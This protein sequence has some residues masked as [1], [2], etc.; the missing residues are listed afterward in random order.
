MYS[1]SKNTLSNESTM[2]KIAEKATANSNGFVNTTGLP[3]IYFCMQVSNNDVNVA[4]ATKIRCERAT[5]H[6]SVG[7][8]DSLRPRIVIIQIQVMYMR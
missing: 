5:G 2:L 6:N 4:I 8:K 3:S 1:I 7:L